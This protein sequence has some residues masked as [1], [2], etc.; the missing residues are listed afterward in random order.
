M[1]DA[2]RQEL[3]SRSHD[4]DVTVWVGKRGVEAAVDE[5]REQLGDREVVKARLHRAAGPDVEDA[6]ETLASQA[7]AE[8]VDVRGRTALF[9]R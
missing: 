4:V 1:D 5:L 2:R 9:A 3:R 7:D 6:A 8:I